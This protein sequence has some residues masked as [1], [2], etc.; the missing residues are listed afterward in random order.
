MALQKCF[1]TAAIAQLLRV[2]LHHY[3]CVTT[4]RISFLHCPSLHVL[5]LTSTLL[6]HKLSVYQ[7]S[8]LTTLSWCALQTTIVIYL[9][10]LF[11]YYKKVSQ[12]MGTPKYQKWWFVKVGKCWYAVVQQEPLGV[13]P[14]Q[15]TVQRC[16]MCQAH[17]SCFQ[18]F[19]ELDAKLQINSNCFNEHMSN[20]TAAYHHSPIN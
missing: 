4:C 1:S 2:T 8:C 9:D 5:L 20:I 19:L 15:W 10:T 12:N 13:L 17:W 18:R 6:W 3:N 11:L 14:F 7:V 16:K